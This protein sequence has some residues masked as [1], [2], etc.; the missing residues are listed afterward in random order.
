MAP[1][2]DYYF[3]PQSPWTYLGHDRLT[4]MA[5]AAGATVN[6]L[7]VDFGKVFPLSGG[8]PLGKPTGWWNSRATR[9]C[10]NCR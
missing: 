4:R 1:S 2:V 8:L 3:T 9:S 7:P 10:C 5:N 6:L